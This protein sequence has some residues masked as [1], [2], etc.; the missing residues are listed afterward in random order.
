MLPISLANFISL[1]FLVGGK[2]WILLGMAKNKLATKEKN[3]L[4]EM[5][6]HLTDNLSIDMDVRGF[7][8]TFCHATG[9]NQ[10]FN[11]FGGDNQNYLKF[12]GMI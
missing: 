12:N 9:T 4:Y 2:L 11:T 10:N 8:K 5:S 6:Q 7:F 1:F 3:T